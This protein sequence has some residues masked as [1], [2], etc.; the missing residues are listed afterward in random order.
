MGLGVEGNGLVAGVKAGHEA[1]AAVD[2]EIVVDDWELLLFG[3]VVDVLEVLRTSSSD[4]LEGRHLA[5]LHLGRLLALGPEVEVVDVLLQRLAVLGRRALALPA[6][7]L[8]ILA[9]C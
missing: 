4:V 9:L 2:A 5:E 1:F 3:H 8:Q 7:L 6:L